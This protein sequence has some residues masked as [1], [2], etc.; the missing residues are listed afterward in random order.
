MPMGAAKLADVVT[1]LKREDHKRTKHDSQFSKWKV[2]IGLMTGKTIQWGKE[3]LDTGLKIFPEV[4][5]QD[6][7]SLLYTVLAH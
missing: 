5:P 2:L 7:M 3:S 6:S 1:R 4:K